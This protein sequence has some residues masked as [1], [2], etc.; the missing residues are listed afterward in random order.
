VREQHTATAHC[1]HIMPCL[2]PGQTPANAI[3][4][5]GPSHGRNAL[6]SIQGV[7]SSMLIVDWTCNWRHSVP[8]ERHLISC[9]YIVNRCAELP[10]H[11]ASHCLPAVLHHP[12]SAPKA[13][14]SIAM[15]ISPTLPLTVQTA[16]WWSR[17]TGPSPIQCH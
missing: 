8:N 3:S 12:S 2:L 13:P 14:S 9:T 5:K 1:R 17:W 10:H 15:L 11:G 7:C 4:I 16:G 6:V